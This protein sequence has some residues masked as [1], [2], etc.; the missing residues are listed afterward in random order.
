MQRTYSKIQR[1]AHPKLTSLSLSH[2]LPHLFIWLESEYL[3]ILILSDTVLSKGTLRSLCAALSIP[4]LESMLRYAFLQCTSLQ[5]VFSK[6]GR[7]FR[8]LYAWRR[9]YICRFGY[10]EVLTSMKTQLW[11]ATV[12]IGR[13]KAG[14]KPEDGLWAPW[15]Y[16][17]VHETTE[18][19]A[20]SPFIRKVSHSF[21][22]RL[23]HCCFWF[24]SNL[25]AQIKSP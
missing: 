4:F 24:P 14:P 21:P 12:I 2:I 15:W 6:R 16:S 17:R 9:Q 8:L 23:T 22:P 25:P 13:W 10:L 19:V 11:F 5:C 3:M 18:F 20:P 1:Y 7:A